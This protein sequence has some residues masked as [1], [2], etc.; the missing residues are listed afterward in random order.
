MAI[1]WAKRGQLKLG[2]NNFVRLEVGDEVP[3]AVLDVLGKETVAQLLK[4]GQLADNSAEL[5]EIAER[6]KDAV[7]KA[8]KAAVAAADKVEKKK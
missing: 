3:D 8:A 2:P 7:A 6:A 5:A 4:D 1:I